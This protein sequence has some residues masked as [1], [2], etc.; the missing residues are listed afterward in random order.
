MLQDC[1]PL[2][3]RPPLE[4]HSIHASWRCKSQERKHLPTTL[5]LPQDKTDDNSHDMN[6]VE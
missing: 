2:R 3:Q 5:F 6:D 4:A 1:I